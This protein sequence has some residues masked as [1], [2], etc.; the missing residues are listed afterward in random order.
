MG[1]DE[2]RGSLDSAGRQAG[3]IGLRGGAQQ[4]TS[5]SLSTDGNTAIVG[6]YLDDGAAGAAWVWTRSGGIWTQQGAKLVGSGAVGAAYQGVSVSLSGDGNT[7]IVGGYMDDGA[8]GA[9]WVWTKSGGAWTQQGTKLVGSGAMGMASQGVRVSISADG[10]TA[11]VGGF[12]DNSSAGAAWVWTRSGGVWSQ[13]GTKLVGSGAVGA[14]QQGSSVSL[15]A[16][17]S[18]A[19]VGGSGD[20]SSAGAAWVWTRSSGVWAQQ[21]TKLV[22]SV[23]VGATQQGSSASLSASG[24]RAIVGGF[25]DNGGVGAAWVWTRSGGAWTQ[26][27]TKLLGSDVVGSALQ[28]ISVALSADGSTAI[29]GGSGDNSYAGAAWVFTASAPTFPFP[30]Q[31]IFLAFGL[32]SSFNLLVPAAFGK[33]WPIVISGSIPAATVSDSY[34]NSVTSQI[35]DIFSRSGVRNIEWTTSDSGDAIAVYFCPPVNPELLGYAKPPV[36]RFNSKRRGEVIVFVNETLPNLDAESAAHEVG[37]ALGLRHINPP[38]ATDPSDNEVMDLDFSSAPEFI[39]TVSGVTDFPWISTHNPRYHLLRYVDGWSRAQLQASG[40]NPGTW[41]YG[42][43]IKTRFSFQ[44]DNLRLYNITVFAS[45]GSTESSFAL[46]QIPSATLAELSGR[47]F[48]VPEGV[49][50][51]LLASSTTNGLPDVISSTG[52]AFSSTN[53]IIAASGTNTFSLFRQDSPTNA[54]PVATATAEFDAQSPYCDISLSAPAILRLDFRGTLQNSTNLTDWADVGTNT[55]SPEFIT[56]GQN[57][58]AGFFRSRR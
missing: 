18:T 9:A 49:G 17:G 10:S 45:G 56:L 39:N 15:S 8:T 41:D 46:E 37:H 32:P 35:K 12:T 3:R 21:G 31:K 57:G 14:A 42:S 23:A 53:Q 4:G 25:T 22:G 20:N 2:E 19:I 44:N 58:S 43:T 33:V 40:V 27:G 52:D 11:I 55:T 7:A 26:Q 48:T 30:P 13:Q 24:N 50:I 28:G 34:R 16:D 47:S 38:A 6:G 54:V 51:V 1:L 29:V 36:D 5:V